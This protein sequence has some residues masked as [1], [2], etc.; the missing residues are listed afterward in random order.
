MKEF[1]YWLSVIIP[2]YNS[3]KTL[4]RCVDS[5]L[6]SGDQNIEIIL[7]DDG[8]KDKSIK[9]CDEYVQGYD[10]IKAFHFENGGISVARNRGISIASGKY[11]TFVDSDDCVSENFY[12]KCKAVCERD[13]IDLLYFGFAYV[14]FDEVFPNINQVIPSNV[15]LDRKFIYEKIIPPLVNI[16]EDK[17]FFIDNYVMNK[18][19]RRDILVQ[20]KVYFDES[21]RSWEDRPFITEYCKYVES[22]EF[23]PEVGYY[24]MNTEESLSKRFSNEYLSM[25]LKN[26]KHNE[27]L[28]GKEYDFY[29]G[30][31]VQYY[32]RAFINN[33]IDLYQFGEKRDEIQSM[34]DEF[35]KDDLAYKLFQAFIP[36]SQL[37]KNV[38]N[39]I[40]NRNI[41]KIDYLLYQ[42]YI[43]KNRVRKINRVKSIVQRIIKNRFNI[44]EFE[45]VKKC[46]TVFR[47]MY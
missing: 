2:I 34:I 36:Q 46:R 39:C 5:I 45:S 42:E 24:Y 19:Y 8:S 27:N 3:E 44:D 33:T 31:P 21:R 43:K 37:E 38:Y 15:V 35:C 22:M 16:V 23:I 13:S 40:L 29:H 26:F 6:I 9:I 41:K 7:V 25:I 47:Q 10:F 28:F 4:R 30:Y 32:C 11:V 18:I 1:Q 20:N 17:Q 12:S 14:S